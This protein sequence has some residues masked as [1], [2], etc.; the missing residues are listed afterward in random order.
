MKKDVVSVAD[1]SP[2]RFRRLLKLSAALQKEGPSQRLSGQVVALLFQKPSLRTKVSFSIAMTQLGGNSVYLA[3][4]EVGLGKRE[5]I[6]DVARVLSRFV[7]AIVFRAFNHRDV[8]LMA[9]HASVPVINALSDA[10]H[11]CQ[12]LADLFTIEQKK[13][14]LKGQVISFIG[15]GNNVAAS[16]ALGAAMMGSHFRIA[17][18]LGYELPKPVL[19]RA[20]ALAEFS[21]GS[22]SQ[23]VDPWTAVKMADVVYTDTWTSMGQEAETESRR[24]A[25]K[26][27][28]VNDELFSLAQADALFMHPLPAHRDQEVTSGVMDNPRSAIFDE[29]ENRLH[30]QKALLVDLLTERQRGR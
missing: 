10:E 13:G 26:S 18:P 14:D 21:G 15:D 24:L 22:V 8:E 6:E 19:A 30:V 29:A 9:Q 17:S 25:F 23:M 4:E 12:A 28:Q 11:P 2:E 20:R 16:L 27:Y 3:P 1:L 7:Q 5:S